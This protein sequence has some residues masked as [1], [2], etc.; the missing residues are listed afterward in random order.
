V[1][2]LSF[3]AEKPTDGE[4]SSVGDHAVVRS[5]GL[6]FDMPTTVQNFDRAEVNPLSMQ[7]FTDL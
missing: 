1:P 6:A 7:G 4:K 5:Y 2:V 3:Q